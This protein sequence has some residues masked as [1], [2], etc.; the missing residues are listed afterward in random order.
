MFDRGAV[1]YLYT[2]TPLHPGVGAGAGWVDLPIQREVHTGHPLVQGPGVKGAL[3]GAALRWAGRAG[4]EQ[5]ERTRRNG[6]VVAVF[7]PETGNAADHA[8]CL[9]VGDARALLFP[10][11]SFSGVFGWV[12]CPGVL[13]RY[14]RDAL[15]AGLSGLPEVPP[16]PGGDHAWVAQDSALLVGTGEGGCVA[17]E[18]VAFGRAETGQDGSCPVAAWAKH[19]APFLPD[20]FLADRL[21]NAL[22]VVDDGA[23]AYFVRHRTE[24]VTRIRM[25]PDLGTARDQGLWTEELLPPDTLLYAPLAA[26]RPRTAASDGPDLEDGAQ[27]LGWLWNEVLGANPP[28]PQGGP[29]AGPGPEGEAPGGRLL[30]LGGGATVGRGVVWTDLQPEPPPAPR[31]SGG[32]V[33]P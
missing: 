8:G 3:R 4:P 23:F 5:E 17:L 9:S 16:D 2:E 18:D 33:G 22:A 31:G 7:G 1:L 32:E 29:P 14:R 13:A 11:A 30:W 21:E 10:V 27:V 6:A 20:R 12:T 25:D 15:R 19:L 28:K 24:V 26:G